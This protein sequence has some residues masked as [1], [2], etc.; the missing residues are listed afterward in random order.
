MGSLSI[1]NHS[2]TITHPPLIS[3]L[4]SL[5]YHLP[6]LN[7][8]H[9]SPILIT[10]CPSTLLPL[11]GTTPPN[12]CLNGNEHLRRCIHQ[13]RFEW[14]HPFNPLKWH[15]T[16]NLTIL[17]PLPF[18]PL[19]NL[20]CHSQKESNHST[21]LCNHWIISSSSYLHHYICHHPKP[22][23]EWNQNPFNKNKTSSVRHIHHLR[24]CSELFSVLAHTCNWK[25]IE[26]KRTIKSNGFRE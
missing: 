26:D 17:N 4:V 9:S 10:R 2:Q 22:Y 1:N 5:L 11:L 19:L 6:T 12:Q 15:I 8:T 13:H 16:L 25:G 3:N 20:E 21:F 24:V 18:L 14:Y 23:V 7:S